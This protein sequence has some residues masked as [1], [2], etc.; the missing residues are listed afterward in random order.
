MSNANK[1]I[2]R[3]EFEQILNEGN[4]AVL[5]ELIDQDYV[6]YDPTAPA[7]WRGPNG[8][9]QSLEPFRTAFPGLRVRVEDQVAEGD[10]VATRWIFTG[11]H[12]GEFFGIPPTGKQVEITGISI[13][14]VAGGR[15]VEDRM[16]LDA[17]GLMRQLG[18]VPGEPAA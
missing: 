8:L 1:Q 14:R 13:E 6:L 12:D 9:R 7:P 3:R 16:E 15:I 10:K 17:L 4:D 2:I 18:A 11:R 5:D